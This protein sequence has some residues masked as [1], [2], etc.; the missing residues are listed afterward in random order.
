MDHIIWRTRKEKRLL[1]N[2]NLLSNFL[3]SEERF[4]IFDSQG[5]HPENTARAFLGDSIRRGD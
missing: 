3:N 1:I 2:N 4:A 5:L